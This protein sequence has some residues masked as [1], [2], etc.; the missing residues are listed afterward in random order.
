M[1][2]ERAIIII[3]PL[4]DTRAAETITFAESAQEERKERP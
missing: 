4:S 3:P 2:S 1:E